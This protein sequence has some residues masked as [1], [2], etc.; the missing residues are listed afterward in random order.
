MIWLAFSMGLFGSLHCVGMCGPIAWTVSSIGNG[1][2][3]NGI[4]Q[5][6]QYNTGRVVTYAMLGLLLGMIGELIVLTDFQKIFSIIAGGFLVVL[7]LLSLDIERLLNRSHWYRMAYSNVS[8]MLSSLLSKGAVK[9]PFLLG[10]VNGLLPCGLVYLALTGS[11]VSGG[12]I[13]GAS[14]MLLFGLGTF[15]A[16]IGIMIIG[17]K[18][19]RTEVIR[20]YLPRVFQVTQL[21]LGIF[22]IYRGIAIN[23]PAELDFWTAVQNPVMCH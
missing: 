23:V 15:P 9:Y 14:F 4:F 8:N 12:S 3:K 13:E 19:S 17:Q 5:A 2:L 18:S 16:M 10:V 22:L 6:I 21:A 1:Q 20:K 7:F 11:V